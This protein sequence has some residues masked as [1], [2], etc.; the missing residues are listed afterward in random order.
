MIKEFYIRPETDP[1]YKPGIL[2]TN[3][4]DET[5]VNQ[6]KIT[7]GTTRTNVLGEVDFGMNLIDYL[8]QFDVDPNSISN[9]MSDQVNKYSEI[10]RIHNIQFDAKKV[11]TFDGK[12]A[13]LADMKI[14]GK[15]VLGF[16]L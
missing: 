6:V 15:N 5:L 10:A 4:E 14:G 7:L 9:E 11:K 1:Y 8:Y 13:I 2:E 3:R 12:V 16:L